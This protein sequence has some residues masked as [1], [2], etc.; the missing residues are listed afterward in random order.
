[1][2]EK[3]M[4]I[5]KLGALILAGTLMCTT[6]VMPVMASDATETVQEIIT[7]NEIDSLVSDPDKVVDMIF[8]YHQI[9]SIFQEG[10]YS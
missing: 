1:M 10:E 8:L 7:D 9:S 4:R 2:E 3:I 5:K 6:P